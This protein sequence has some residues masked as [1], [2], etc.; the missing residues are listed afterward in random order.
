MITK[1]EGYDKAQAITGEFEQLP[2]GGYVCQIMGAKET[3][4]R[5]NKPMLELSL[6]IA[7]GDCKGFFMRSYKANT[8][9]DKKWGCIYRQMLTNESAGF[10]KGLVDDIEKSNGFTWDFD[11][12][13]L[14]GKLIGMLFQ[15]E[16]Y[17]K[18][19]NS[20][21]L[22][23]KPF[24]PRQ[25]SVIRE[26]DFTIPEDKPLKENYPYDGGAGLFGDNDFEPLDSEDMPF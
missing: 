24:Q 6:D 20:I 22:F 15:R 14:K 3:R 13:K 9:E 16:E 26:G 5:T 21:G 11:E 4:S 25:V 12:K 19:D 1:P 8:R 10:L 18:K 17:R 2:A 7:E 23:T